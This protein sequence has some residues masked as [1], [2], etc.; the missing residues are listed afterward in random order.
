M[1]YCPKCGAPLEDHLKFCTKCGAPQPGLEVKQEEN[2]IEEETEVKQEE[3][4]L[5]DRERFNNLLKTDERFKNIVRASKLAGLFTLINFLFLIPFFVNLFTPVGAFTGVDVSSQGMTYFNALG[6]N[7]FP[8]GYSAMSIRKFCAFAK[9]GGW[10]ITPDDALKGQTALIIFIFGLVFSAL[11]VV[12]AVVGRPNGYLL[13]T[14]EKQNG[15]IELIK[16]IKSPFSYVYGAAFVVVSAIPAVGTYVN[17][18][19]L[20]YK[21]GHYVLGQV[22]GLKSGLATVIV[23]S[24]L[25][26]SLI[27]AA[28]IV[29]R[30]IFVNK[31]INPY[32]QDIKPSTGN[33]KV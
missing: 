13:R 19:G 16:A 3:R 12:I 29:L 11:L 9:A 23:V 31:L 14:Y 24:L 5:S 4:P 22:T 30:V 1:K 20:N 26:I 2:R 17:S 10:K 32:T 18:T 8:H 28:N 33:D 21:D 7:Y 27:I 25:F 15:H 6:I